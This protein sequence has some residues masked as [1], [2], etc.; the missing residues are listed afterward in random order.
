MGRAE[1]R[2]I[3]GVLNVDKST[4]MTSHDVV[5]VIRRLYHVRKVGHTGTLDPR[6]TGVLPICVGRATKIAQFLTTADKEYEMV[7]RLGVS[8]D[9]QD[10]DGKVIDEAEVRVTREGVEAALRNFMGEVQQVP[11]LFSAKR[12]K[13]E[14][15]YKMARRGEDVPRDPVTVRIYG[16][17]LISFGPPLVGLWV[18][19]SKG[20]YARTLADDLGKMLGCGA[21]LHSLVRVRAGRFELKDA[22]SLNELTAMVADGRGEEPL[23]PVEE[24][25]DHLP[26]ARVLPEAS[27]LILHGSP[28]T[29]A[30]V[31]SVPPEVGK[32]A[33]VRVLGFRRHLLS[34]ATATVD[35]A[36]FTQVDPRR[37]VLTPVRVFRSAQSQ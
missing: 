29:A 23:I 33:V 18:H 8:T 2:E 6:G 9:T 15:L 34:L 27:R 12:V 20:T 3:S 1:A 17:R 31:V 36:D 16:I 4:G 28:V 21:H 30:Q 19:C 37:V 11:P 26:A 7:V 22:L 24:A 14:R 10:A 5:D 13:G 35:A 32:G 25:L